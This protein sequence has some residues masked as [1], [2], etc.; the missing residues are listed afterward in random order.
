MQK[1]KLVF[2]AVKKKDEKRYMWVFQVKHLKKEKELKTFLWGSVII[3]A[4]TM[5]FAHQ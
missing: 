5:F 1:P 2:I 4:S 3:S